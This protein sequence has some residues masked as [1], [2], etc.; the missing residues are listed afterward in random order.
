MA[1]LAEEVKDQVDGCLQAAF[2]EENPEVF[3]TA[4]CILMQEEKHYRTLARLLSNQVAFK[5]YVLKMVEPPNPQSQDN[6]PLSEDEVEAM[7]TECKDRF[8]TELQRMEQAGIV[9]LSMQ[10]ALKTSSA[11]FFVAG[12]AA[13]AVFA[14]QA[15]QAM[16][17]AV[18][19][20][21]ASDI[22]RISSFAAPDLGTFF[23]TRI[24]S[25]V[26]KNAG[27]AEKQ[28]ALRA[29]TLANGSKLV[30]RAGVVL[31]VGIMGYQF[32]DNIRKYC[33]GE[34]DGY[35]LAENLTSVVV[36]TGASAAGAAGAVALC[37]GAGPPGLIFA[38]IAG[39]MCAAF[40][41]DFVFRGAFQGL[42][43][44]LSLD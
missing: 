20:H 40:C 34:I 39:G 12:R 25:N 42:L 14:Q 17:T 3:G 16:A 6:T 9:S 27:D 8:G 7:L 23:L 4:L 2:G 11:T 10:T 38:G 5:A 43:I 30:A 31:Q 37:A 22:L 29:E 33:K 35:T 18:A 15:S 19:H 32:Y 1:D 24:A 28:L 41:S 21:L 26:L 36:T 13:S 44:G